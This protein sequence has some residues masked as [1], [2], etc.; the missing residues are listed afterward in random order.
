MVGKLGYFFLVYLSV[1]NYFIGFILIHADQTSNDLRG[2]DL[3]I[4]LNIQRLRR[5]VTR[6]RHALG[7]GHDDIINNKPVA[8]LEPRLDR[9][10]AILSRHLDL[11]RDPV[12]HQNLDAGL[13]EQVQ[14]DVL[15]LVR[16]GLGRQQLVPG[17]CERHP[18]VRLDEL[19]LCGHLDADGAAADHEDSVTRARHGL[20]VR[21][22]LEE[23]L[24]A[25]GGLRHDGPHAAE[26]RGR[27][28]EVVGD[29]FI[30]GGLRYC[31]WVGP[32]DDCGL[33]ESIP[34]VNDGDININGDFGVL[35]IVNSCTTSWGLARA[36]I[37]QVEG[38]GDASIGTADD[39]DLMFSKGQV[40]KGIKAMIVMVYGTELRQ[41]TKSG[42]GLVLEG[43]EQLRTWDH[44][45]KRHAHL[46]HLGPAPWMRGAWDWVD[47]MYSNAM[48]RH[49]DGDGLLDRPGR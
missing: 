16:Q 31:F 35:R 7:D 46:G 26:T 4:T 38:G 28:E 33:G 39:E 8:I 17:V 1:F 10:A 20:H 43:N 42:D 5:Q 13:T 47:I 41:G 49:R 6:R 18:D 21:P 32:A 48:P 36:E 14:G 25:A 11:L 45:N 3:H 40:A 2:L 19:E 23:V 15:A 12:A 34:L 24:L 37:D 9:S 44:S 27:D 22:R 29:E 30:R